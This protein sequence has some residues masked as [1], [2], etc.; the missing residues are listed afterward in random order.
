MV[1]TKCQDVTARF[2]QNTLSLGK[3]LISA[4]SIIIISISISLSASLMSDI[5][6]SANGLVAREVDTAYLRFSG[7]RRG[8]GVGA[9]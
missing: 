8:R 4:Y 9:Y 3:S 7:S 6:M 2:V 5:V 1:T